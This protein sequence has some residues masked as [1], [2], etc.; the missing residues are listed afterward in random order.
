MTVQI[1]S[2]VPAGGRE[3]VANEIGDR[4]RAQLGVRIGVELVELG[5]LEGPTGR[6]TQGKPKR[7]LDRRKS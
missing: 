7:F 4:L 3:Q 1:E 2:A 6:L 5:A